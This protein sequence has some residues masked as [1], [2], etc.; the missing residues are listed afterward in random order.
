MTKEQLIKKLEAIPGNP[1]VYYLKDST[2][3]EVISVDKVD[4]DS[5][6]FNDGYYKTAFNESFTAEEN[7]LT[8]EV[9]EKIKSENE[10]SIII[11]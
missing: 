8:E 10:K 5:I 3:D 2:Y 4:F 6:V 11:W 1:E 7:H 9:W